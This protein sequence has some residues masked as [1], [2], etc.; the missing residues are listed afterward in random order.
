MPEETRSSSSNQGNTPSDPPPPPTS[1]KDTLL[2]KIKE[3]TQ[4]HVTITSEFTTLQAATTPD[5]PAFGLKVDTASVKLKE[6]VALLATYKGSI[7]KTGAGD[8]TANDAVFEDYERL[9]TAITKALVDG[10]KIKVEVETSNFES[11]IFTQEFINS[12]ADSNSETNP[13]YSFIMAI[14]DSSFNSSANKIQHIENLSTEEESKL[15]HALLKAVLDALATESVKGYLS[16]T[17]PPNE[18]AALL[19]TL[20]PMFTDTNSSLRTEINKKYL[21]VAPSE[22]GGG[23]SSS[24]SKKNRKSHKSYHPDIGKTRKHHYN[25]DHKRVS[26]VH[27]A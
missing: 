5:W 17:T 15:N 6:A 12:Y 13:I 1:K 11:L 7:G 10:G 9:Y 23:S 8:N 25:A 18:L 20:T 16:N 4:G 3:V 14:K 19:T 21:T 24:S 22:H 2:A 26:F 27:Q